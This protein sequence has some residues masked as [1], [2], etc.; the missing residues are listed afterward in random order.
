SDCAMP[1]PMAPRPIT[2]ATRLITLLLQPG[3]FLNVDFL[4]SARRQAAEKRLNGRLIHMVII[5]LAS[6]DPL[7]GFPESGAANGSVLQRIG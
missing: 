5:Q 2:P 7:A 4:E 1:L 6:H 3:S